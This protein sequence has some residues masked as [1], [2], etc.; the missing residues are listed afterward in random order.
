MSIFLQPLPFPFFPPQDSPSFQLDHSH[1]NH[2][3]NPKKKG[4][5]DLDSTNKVFTF[6]LY[7]VSFSLAFTVFAPLPYK[8]Q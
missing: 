7:P 6:S 2:L 3:Q 4:H 1:Y 8:S 5:F